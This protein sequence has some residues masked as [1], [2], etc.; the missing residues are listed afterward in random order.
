MKEEEGLPENAQRELKPGEKYEPIMSSDK[1]YPEVKFWSV[2]WRL[3]MAVVFTA[4]IAYPA[5]INPANVS[6]TDSACSEIFA[7]VMYI[8]IIVYFICNSMKHSTNKKD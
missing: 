7:I 5:K 6:R 4:A 8:A 3:A 2:V 1:N